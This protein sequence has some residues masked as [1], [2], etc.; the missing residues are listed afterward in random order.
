MR[1]RLWFALHVLAALLAAGA[2][3]AEPIGSHF[4][5]TPFGGFTMF[6]PKL[7]YPGSNAPLTDDLYVGGRLS[8]ES[9]TWIGIE[10]AAGMTP[11]VEDLVVGGND[12]D[13]THASGNLVLSPA[14]GRWGNPTCSPAPATRSSSPPRARSAARTRSSSAAA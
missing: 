1:A 13:W 14:R 7:R 5:L 11:T 4:Q 10:A 3:V 8:W 9:K 2:A 12:Y 6:D